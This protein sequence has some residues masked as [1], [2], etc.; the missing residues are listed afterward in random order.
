MPITNTTALRRKL[1]DL[2]ME[3]LSEIVFWARYNELFADSPLKPKEIRGKSYLELAKLACG[4]VAGIRKRFP[5]EPSE[6]WESDFVRA[7]E[8]KEGE[9]KRTWEEEWPILCDGKRLI[10]DFHE[11]VGFKE[12]LVRLK[13]RIIKGMEAGRT[14]LWQEAE[15]ELATLAQEPTEFRSSVAPPGS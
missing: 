4:R 6:S 3:Q 13:I 7:C 9:L 12:N 2:A 1:K 8:G 14:L 10:R 15:R 11:E 5:A